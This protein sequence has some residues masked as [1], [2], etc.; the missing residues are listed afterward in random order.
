MKYRVVKLAD[1]RYQSQYR[2]LFL[3]WIDSIHG[4]SLDLDDQIRWALPDPKRP[5][6]VGI[7]WP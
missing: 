4:P 6:A 7:V 1:G 2:V 3:W 5:K